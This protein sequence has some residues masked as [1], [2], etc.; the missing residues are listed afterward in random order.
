MRFPALFMVILLGIATGV[1]RIFAVRRDQ[2]WPLYFHVFLTPIP[3]SWGFPINQALWRCQYS[4]M[5]WSITCVIRPF[6]GP[7]GP[8]WF[9][10]MVREK[11]SLIS[12]RVWK[13]L[14]SAP[15]GLYLG[16]S[17]GD[18]ADQVASF[19]SQWFAVSGQFNDP[20]IHDIHRF[21]SVSCRCEAV[22]SGEKISY[23]SLLGRFLV[24]PLLMASIVYWLPSS[25]LD[26]ASLYHPVRYACDD[27]CAS[28]CQTLRCW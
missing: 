23:W 11:R 15:D 2:S 21:V 10:G 7:W 24:A 20:L 27:Q 1:A 14:F 13:S 19:S 16:T 6:S 8:I 12:K 5:F 3:S 17:H 4:P 18:A 26:E 25:K 28:C 22:G 9:S